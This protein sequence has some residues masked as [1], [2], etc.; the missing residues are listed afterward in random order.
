MLFCVRIGALYPAKTT[1][2]QRICPERQPLESESQECR[3]R[4]R[5][6]TQTP[7]VQV[8]A[9]VLECHGPDRSAVTLKKVVCSGSAVS[10]S[11][12]APLAA[13]TPRPRSLTF[14]HNPS[15]GH[16]FSLTDTL[17]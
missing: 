11:F 14:I 4:D 17:V 6:R 10:F 5:P 16:N 8:P 2:V 15:S 9:P 3:G 13:A 7:D 12:P 1:Y